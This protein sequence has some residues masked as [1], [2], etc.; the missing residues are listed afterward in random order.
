MLGLVLD[1]Y[2]CVLWLDCVFYYWLVACCYVWLCCWVA[3]LA[4]SLVCGFGS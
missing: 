2:V 3:M 4:C 1:C